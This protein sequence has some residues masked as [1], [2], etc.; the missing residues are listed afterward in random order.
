MWHCPFV[1]VFVWENVLKFAEVSSIM[2]FH[3]PYENR[4]VDFEAY[5]TE[6]LN[7]HFRETPYWRKKLSKK[8]VDEVVCSSFEETLYNL[9][10]LEVDQNLLRTRWMDFKPKSLRNVKCSFSSSTTGPQ[11]YCL[12]SE[13][14]AQKQAE[15][16]H[17][18]VE[19]MGVKVKNA[20]IQGPTSVYKDVNE[21]V[22]QLF[23]GIPY[24]VGLRVEGLKPIIEDA[25]RKGP[26]EMMKVVKEYFAPE[27]EKTRRF[28]ENDDEINFMRSA[29]MM[30][31]PFEA[32]FGDKGNIEAVMTSGLGYSVENHEFLKQKFRHVIPSYGYF[33]FGDALGR[34]FNGNLDYY[35]AFPYA[36]F[37]V[38]KED[39]EI[40]KNGEKGKPLFIT[41]RKDLFLVLKENNEYT[42]KAPPT[43]NQP[44]NGIRNPQRKLA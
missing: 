21:R 16:I 40:A 13:D 3:V 33:A 4:K 38:V 22:I 17:Y 14:Y 34:Y 25:A 12:W 18:Y 23:G 41:A 9:S 29:W 37:T 30:L 5:L 31:A 7:H 42:E 44:W 35:P 20:V 39:G 10:K 6:V 8:L 11:K 26:E 27:I 15:Y 2:Q 43:E 36:A 1:D 24:F 19:K 28:L 32:F